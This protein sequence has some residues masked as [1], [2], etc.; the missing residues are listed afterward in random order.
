MNRL[1]SFLLILALAAIAHAQ[2]SADTDTDP[3][4]D[5]VGRFEISETTLSLL[6]EQSSQDFQVI[7]PNDQAITWQVVVPKSYN[8]AQPA[9]VLVYV[10]PSNSGKIPKAWPE[11]LAKRN[12]IWVSANESGNKINPHLRIAYATLAVAAVAKRY[13]VDTERVYVSGFSGGG[14]IASVTISEYP[15]LFKGGIYI[16]GVLSHATKSDNLELLKQNR[17]V[18]V[19]GRKDFNYEPTKIAYRK[20]KKAGIDAS[21]LLVIP[22]LKHQNP[23]AEGIDQALS[24]LNASN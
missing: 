17:H 14:K 21:E 12:L 22:K 23:N 7:I 20:Y 4:T 3:D 19:T 15:Q 11:I 10:S 8:K 5:R 1:L 2:E 18:F 9:G 6:G 16:C 24:F 13:S